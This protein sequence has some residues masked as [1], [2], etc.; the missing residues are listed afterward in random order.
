MYKWIYV[1]I[2]A[3]IHLRTTFG[4]QYI[5]VSHVSVFQI[6]VEASRAYHKA[7]YEAIRN[8][9]QPAEARVHG[10]Q[11]VRSLSGHSARAEDVD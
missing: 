4:G 10:R 9:L 1:Y 7:H 11:A 8:G 2:Y 3:Y 5:Y 6:F